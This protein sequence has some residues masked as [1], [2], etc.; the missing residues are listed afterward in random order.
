MSIYSKTLKSIKS[1]NSMH[2]FPVFITISLSL[3]VFEYH[4]N[5]FLSPRKALYWGNTFIQLLIQTHRVPAL[6]VGKVVK[7]IAADR[8][9]TESER[10]ESLSYDLCS[11]QHNNNNNINNINNNLPLMIINN[12]NNNYT[13]LL[14]DSLS[15]RNRQWRQPHKPTSH[16]HD[17]ETPYTHSSK[18]YRIIFGSI[19]EKFGINLGLFGIILGSIFGINL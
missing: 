17:T 3:R 18:Q 10:D 7:D 1:D 2:D 16:A 5:F 15:L 12:N 19:L 9:T 6:A 14:S 8:N 13:E 4:R 11:K